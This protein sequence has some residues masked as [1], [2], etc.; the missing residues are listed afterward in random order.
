MGQNN[1]LLKQYMVEF[2][3]PSPLS[4]EF[5]NMIPA[6]RASL[7]SLFSRGKLLTYTVAADRSRVWGVLVASTESELLSY[8][9]ELPMTTYMDYDYYELMFYNTVHLMPAMSWN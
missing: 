3:V 2:E 4:E 7:D 6:Q 1:D 8:L 9:D 5:L